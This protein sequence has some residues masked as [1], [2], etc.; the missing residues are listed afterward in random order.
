M[1]VTVQGSIQGEHEVIRGP[2]LNTVTG[3][4]TVTSGECGMKVRMVTW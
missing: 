4:T 2:F 3:Q 1:D